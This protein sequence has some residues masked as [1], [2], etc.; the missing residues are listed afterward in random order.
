MEKSTPAGGSLLHGRNSEHGPT[1][2]RT[3]R[4]ARRSTAR[5]GCDRTRL[6]IARAQPENGLFLTV[7]NPRK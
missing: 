3:A 6:A 7:C 1:R 5:I 2:T 4:S